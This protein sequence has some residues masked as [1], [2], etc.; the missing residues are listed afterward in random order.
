M[1][2][3]SVTPDPAASFGLHQPPFPR[4]ARGNSA[5]N[6]VSDERHASTFKRLARIIGPPVVGLAVVLLIT[7]I[8]RHVP[9]ANV[10]TESVLY[11]LVPMVLAVGGGIWVYAPQQ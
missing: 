7:A 8:F 5:E 6:S 1:S 11:Y 4:H 2:S 9:L 3:K 10:T